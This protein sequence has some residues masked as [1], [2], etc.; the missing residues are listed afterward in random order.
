MWSLR[1][2]RNS[3]PALIWLPVAQIA[4][5]FLQGFCCILTPRRPDVFHEGK[6]VDQ[7]YTVS[8]ASRFTFAWVSGLLEDKVRNKTLNMK[9]LP[10]LPFSLR[11]QTLHAHFEQVRGSRKLWKALVIVHRRPLVVQYVL[12]LLSCALSFGPQVAL[13]RILRLL[14]HRPL[15]S[16]EE[17]Q[18]WFWVAGLGLIMVL[19]FTVDSWLWWMMYSEL[20]VPVHAE[21]SA[22]V[23]AKSMRC[24]NVNS[25]E[26]PTQ[27]QLAQ[28]E[29]L[30]D[31]E[32]DGLKKSRQRIVNLAAVDTKRVADFAAFNFL[33][34]F[35]IFKLIISCAF[36]VT[37][38]GWKSLLAGLTVAALVAPINT[39]LAKRYS[40]A[41]EQFMKASDKRIAT[42]TEVLQG[43]RQ[44]KFSATENQ[45]EEKVAEKRSAELDW[46]WKASCYTSGLISVWILGPLMLSAASLT[47]YA[48]I[49]GKLTPSIA[50][51]AMS[52]F[53]SLEKS[54][55][56]LP[57][58]LSR[59]LEAKISADRIDQYM[60][61]SER[62]FYTSAV[63]AIAFENAKIAWPAEGGD[64]ER[65]NRSVGVATDRFILHDLNLRFPSKCLSVIAGRTAS[66]K[67]LLLASIIG[68][69]DILAGEVRVPCSPPLEDRFD[70]QAIPASWIIDSAIAYVAQNPWIE[71]SN[72]KDNILFGLPY[73]RS[74]YEKVLFACRLETDLSSLPDGDLTEIGANGVTLSGG[75]RCRVCFA[76]AL[77]SRAGILILDDI[78]SALDAHTGRHVFEHGLTGELGQNRTRILVTHHVS[79]CLPRADY[80]VLLGEGSVQCAGPAE[81]LT[82]NES[83]ADIASQL[84]DAETRKSVAEGEEDL[85]EDHVARSHKPVAAP[86]IRPSMSSKGSI[87]LKFSEEKRTTGSIPLSICATYLRKGKQ[88]PL[89]V[90]ALIV[91][92]GYTA[93]IFGRVSQLLYH[94]VKLMLTSLKSPGVSTSGL[95][96]PALRRILH[97]I[98]PS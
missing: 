58:A 19:A 70:L 85:P 62:K 22:L 15:A 26:S 55:S 39:I 21:L 23:F 8:V 36:L 16:R 57:D 44:I 17:S 20:G 28:K 1:T 73:D 38:I 12:S 90:L 2:H 87:P 74:R 37:L 33:V 34:P 47:T 75:Q 83:L 41:Q 9:D 81:M 56:S 71:N 31:E 69:C 24:K 60:G 40:A 10:S 43:I 67:S 98:L 76:R 35:S 65:S 30:A 59:G 48:L 97:I 88:L 89:W 13:Y 7:Q 51:T 92:S 72:I 91:Y 4:A 52:I 32:D 54:L 46:L 78:F 77:Y 50:F 53:G 18:A 6:V 3:D 64:D 27:P 66:G 14:E 5:A 63:D 68:E 11:S 25:S 86:N 49:H 45:W 84:Q 94:F 29:M 79:L 95:A 80:Y 42:V 96:P 61:A 82:R 93:L